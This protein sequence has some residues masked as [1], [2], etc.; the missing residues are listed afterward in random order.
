VLLSKSVTLVLF[1]RNLSKAEGQAW[2]INDAIPLLE[3]MTS[4]SS[5]HYEDL[6]RSDIIVV[7]IG[8]TLTPGQ[9]RLELLCENAIT[10]ADMNKLFHI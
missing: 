1:D 3:E 9:S 4:I 6:A 5:N 8:A 10:H 2:D 7:T